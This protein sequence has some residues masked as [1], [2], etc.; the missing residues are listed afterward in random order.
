M[1]VS[2][3]AGELQTLVPPLGDHF[4]A[5]PGEHIFQDD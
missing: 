3:M 1:Y 4:I 5:R 2:E